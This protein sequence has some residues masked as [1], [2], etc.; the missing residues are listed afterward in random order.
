MHT[1]SF[2]FCSLLFLSQHLSQL[3][4]G[5]GAKDQ[6]RLGVEVLRKWCLG[7]AKETTI[8]Q[9]WVQAD[10]STKRS[11]DGSLQTKDQSFVGLCACLTAGILEQLWDALGRQTVI[12][13]SGP[14]LCF[15][16]W[17]TL[18]AETDAVILSL[19]FY[20]D[21]VGDH[22]ELRPVVCWSAL[23]LCA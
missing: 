14:S 19:L 10:S 15:P 23:P 11:S 20:S 7:V 2:I 17:E 3:S 13:N 12:H 16:R 6:P 22:T 1:P 9:F 8:S 18:W 4:R 5:E 21:A